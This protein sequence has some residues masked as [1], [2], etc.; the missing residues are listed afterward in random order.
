MKQGDVVMTVKPCR[1]YADRPVEVSRIFVLLGPCWQRSHVHVHD[2]KS[3][4]AWVCLPRN[5]LEVL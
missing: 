1:D 4:A 5:A 3:D 2:K